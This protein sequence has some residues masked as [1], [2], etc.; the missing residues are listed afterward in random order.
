[1]RSILGP[2]ARAPAAA[3]GSL[4]MPRA[5]AAARLSALQRA[6]GEP[7]AAPAGGSRGCRSGAGTGGGRARHSAQQL[8][9]PRMAAPGGAGSWHAGVDAVSGLAMSTA[10]ASIMCSHAR[11]ALGPQCLDGKCS[12]ADEVLL[13]RC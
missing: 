6:A 3:G 12:F 13:V 8:W 11:P 7:V 1:M 4:P 10:G 9:H 2:T 5:A